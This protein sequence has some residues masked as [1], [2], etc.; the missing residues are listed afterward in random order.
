M[1]LRLVREAE[2]DVDAPHDRLIHTSEICTALGYVMG[3]VKA[4]NAV[5]LAIETL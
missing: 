3:A 5:V 4:G 1:P 2:R